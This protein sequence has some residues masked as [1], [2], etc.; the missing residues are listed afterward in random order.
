MA[1]IKVMSLVRI[2]VCQC[3]L[4]GWFDGTVK[5]D[6]GLEIKRFNW[7][8]LGIMQQGGKNIEQAATSSQLALNFFL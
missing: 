1:W 4:V 7:L 5:A 3:L 8:A 2:V 6:V